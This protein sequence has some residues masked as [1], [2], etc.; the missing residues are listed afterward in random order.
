MMSNDKKRVLVIDGNNLYIRNYVVNPAISNKGDPIGGIFGTIKSLQ[1][2]CREIK[3]NRIVFAWD[4]KGGSSKRRAI[5]KN[6]KEGR[7]PFRLNRNVRSLNENQELENKIWQMTRVVEYLNNFP[8][9]Q[10]LL[11]AVEADD[12]ISAI[13]QHN[14]LKDYNKIIVSNDK[15]F[16]QL[17]NDNTI[18]YRPVKEEILNTKRIVEEYGIHPTNFCLAR[19]IA[20]DASDNLSGVGGAGLATIAKRLP[21]LK[22]EKTFMLDEIFN[23]CKSI[24]SKVKLYST[25][26]ANKELIKENYKIMQL[27][28]PNM[29][30]QDMQKVNYALENSE[31][32]FNKTELVTMM[33]KDGFGETN[34]EEMY[35]HMNKIVIENC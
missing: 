5:N 24:D 15:D 6:Y 2:L 18:L 9:I 16:I 7:K 26:E 21:Q 29:S 1:K 32:T 12:I 19:S 13:C 8:I 3:P 34:F 10:L 27:A 11:D 14:S 30:I 23:Y 31:C 35:A 22:E 4:G 28:I 17:C 20:G 25:I 33:L